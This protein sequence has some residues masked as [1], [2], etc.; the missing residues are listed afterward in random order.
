[1]VF[2][3]NGMPRLRLPTASGAARKVLFNA[4]PIMLAVALGLLGPAAL[5]DDED[6]VQPVDHAPDLSAA[7][8]G[9]VVPWADDQG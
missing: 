5:N 2:P 9:D 7:D 4:S 6:D 8:D 3:E 1:M